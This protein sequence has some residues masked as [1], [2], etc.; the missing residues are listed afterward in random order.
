ME[1]A[2]TVVWDIG[3]RAREPAQQDVVDELPVSR[4]EEETW[5][6]VWASEYALQVF[7]GGP[8][9]LFVFTPQNLAC[10]CAKKPES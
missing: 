4:G 1:K 7:T 2:V 6:T 10:P 8:G 9:A 3:S 5:V